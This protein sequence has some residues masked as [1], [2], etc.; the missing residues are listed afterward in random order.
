MVDS[1]TGPMRAGWSSRNPEKILPHSWRQRPQRG[2]YSTRRTPATEGRPT[3]ASEP[4]PVINST[5]ASWSGGTLSA[6]VIERSR[7]SQVKHSRAR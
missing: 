4:L 6:G 2:A 3:S 7:E 1:S 5:M